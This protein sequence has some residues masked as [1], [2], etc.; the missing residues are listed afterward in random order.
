MPPSKVAK[1]RAKLIELLD[2]ITGSGRGVFQQTLHKNQ[3]FPCPGMDVMLHTARHVI[4]H[5][6]RQKGFGLYEQINIC[7]AFVT[8]HTSSKS[9]F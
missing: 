9:P 5:T 4:T 2:I 8:L 7:A 3:V 6:I 1:A